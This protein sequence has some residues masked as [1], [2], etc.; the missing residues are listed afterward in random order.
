M[1]TWRGTEIAVVGMAGRFPGAG[2]VERFWQNL[3]AGVESIR[4]LAREEL[5]ALGA[6]PALADEPS[7][8]P[9]VAM[10]D[11]YADFDARFFGINPREAE[12]MDP[13]Q[14]VFLE[15]A[16]EALEDAGYDPL[17]APGEVGVFA[18]STLSTYLLF[19]LAR[20]QRIVAGADPLQLIVGNA[21]DS[22]TTRVSYKLNLRGP[23]HTV[24][25]AC[26]T[27]LVAVHLA[28]QSLL[29]EACDMALAGGVSIH[30]H[31]AAG[32]RF[33]EGSILSPD[34]HCRPF[35][36]A[37]QGTLFASGVGVVVLKRL[38]DA[39]ADGDTVRAVILG[40]AVNNDGAAKV[41]FTAPSVDG[42]ARVIAEALAVAGVA[43]E[44]I[45]YVEAH[46]T[47]TALGDPVE[48]QALTRAFGAATD[49]RACA[50]G[51]LK[52]NFG[53]LDIAAGVAALIKTVLA[54]E[55]GEIPPSLHLAAPNPRIDF[56][57]SRV[58]VANRLADWPRNGAPR[59]A[60]VSSF[61][62]GGT[63]A[64]VVLEEAPARAAPVV[65]AEAPWQL[66]LLSARSRPALEAA[67]RRL[68]GHL[69]RRP[70]Q[71][72]GD[73]AHTLRVG[74]RPFAERRMAVCRDREDAAAALTALDP[75]RVATAALDEAAGERP[76]A[77]LF[78]GQ[79]SQ[80]LQMARQLFEHEPLFRHELEEC[81]R[82]LAPRLG[83]PLER[84]LYP[85]PGEEEAAAALLAEMRV[86]QPA[87]FAVEHA[88]ARTWMALGITPQAMLGHSLGEYVAACLAGVFTLEEALALVAERGE[89]MQQAPA[90][91]ML[92]VPLPAAE[93]APLLPP[94]VVVAAEN[95]PAVTA[96]AGSAEAITTLEAMF[97][98][99][100]VECRRLHV[101]VAAH[102]P[103]ME[104]IRE[105]FVARVAQ[106]R[107]RPPQIPFV[108]NLTGRWITDAEA[109]DPAYWGRHLCQPVRF[110]AG[111][112]TLLAGSRAAL[113]EVGPGRTLSTL[114]G[115]HPDVAAERPLLASLG[116]PQEKGEPLQRFLAAAGRLWLAGARIDWVAL[117]AGRGRRRVP[118][119]TYP[120]ERQRYWVDPDG[121][122]FS[123]PGAGVP[124]AAAEPL[125]ERPA[126]PVGYVE[127]A[128]EV[129]RRVAA[130]WQELLGVA[131][132][133]REDNF[134][135]L[136]GHSLLA[137]QVASRL[138]E[139]FAV[140][141]PVRRVLEEP[142]V[143]GMAA[144]VAEAL[145]AAA[146]GRPEAGAVALEALAGPIPRE[147][148]SARAPLS[149]AQERMWFLGQLDPGSAAYN[150]FFAVRL[151]GPL[152]V[153]VLGAAF[154]ALAE[155]HEVLRT[156]IVAA[157][158]QPQQ[159]IAPAA[160]LAV[161]LVDLS[162]LAAAPRERALAGVVRQER[163]RLFTLA[164]P[165]LARVTL[166]LLTGRSGGREEAEEHVALL[167]MHHIVSDG[168]ST[169]VLVREVAALYEAFLAGRASPLPPL[170]LQYA[171]FAVW[172]RGYLQGE[173]LATLLAYWTEQL[174]DP[175]PPLR[176]ATDHPRGAAPG[177]RL[178]VVQRTLPPRLAA[179]L[180][181]L[182][183]RARAT[184]FMTL[185][186]GFHTLLYRA[187]GQSDQVIGSPIANRN[188]AAVEGLIGFF[189]NTLALRLRSAPGWSFRA[190]LEEVRQTALDAYAHQDLPLETLVEAL[191]TERGAGVASLF[192]VMFLL[193]NV[194]RPA[195]EVA[196]LTLEL[197]GDEGVADLGASLFDLCLV[198]EESGGSFVTSLTYDA[199]LFTRP[200]AERLLLR[201]E[202]LLAAAVAEP[203]Q[204]LTALPLLA[205]GEERQLLAWSAGDEAPP[206]TGAVH[207][208]F[209]RQAA[210]RPWAPAVVAGGRSV[211][212]GELD[213]RANRLAHHL[214][215][216]GV[217]P[218][219]R[220]AVCVER[221]PEMLV[222]VLA[223]L[224][225]GGAYVPL[226]AAYPAERKAVVLA[227]AGVRVAL[228]HERLAGQLASQVPRVLCLDAPPAALAGESEA[229]PRVAVAPGN[230]AYVLYT[231]G[232]TGRPKGVVVEH[233]ALAAFTVVAR[234]LYAIG[235]ADRVLQFASLAF[236]ASAEEIY[237][238]L[239]AGAALVLR[240]DA[241]LGA[242][243][244]LLE[245][246]RR[247]G[248]TV[249]D[250]PTAYWHEWAAGLEAAG[251]AVGAPLRL[252]ILG[253]ER[254]QPE[255]LASFAAR[256]DPGVRLLNTYGP[257]EATVVAS[258][259]EL[260]ADGVPPAVGEVPIGRP[261]PGVRCHV[262]DPLLHPAPIGLPGELCIG[263]AGLAR[264]Y[265]DR[266][267]WTAER[268][269]PDPVASE[270]GQRLY[271]T[272]DLARW[273]PDGTLEFVGRRD[274]QVKLRGF[275]IELG[276]IEAALRAQP[277]VQD[278]VAAVREDAPGDRRLVAYVVAGEDGAGDELGRDVRAALARQ[279]PDY[280]VPADV[281]P[282]AALPLTP[283]G[284]VDRRALPAPDRGR[285][286]LAVSYVPPETPT[287]E[288]L[289]RLFAAVLG[290]ERVGVR[291]GF[292]ALGGHSLLLVQLLHRVREAFA[293][294]LP[295]RTLYEEPTVAGL[296]LVV[297]ELIL[298][299]I[300]SLEPAR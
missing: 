36:A 14:R 70:E 91:A 232:S 157:E 160:R 248:V 57:A 38:A 242:A 71:S 209:A 33:L 75:Q 112:A 226:D 111:L 249:L 267:D 72:L 298:A 300:E 26:S 264:G 202:M 233:G 131:L 182:G 216:L 65:A 44:T 55:H 147:P 140:E 47:G 149:F 197:L 110:T 120:F 129:E 228:T 95:A 86:A 37:A 186:A 145:A 172:Q 230:A 123:A 243:A 81:S 1:P 8:V 22:L 134:F 142:S 245:A 25:C 165:P 276:E 83:V 98:G 115:Q 170:A 152:Q 189:L 63:N 187:T 143:A 212:Y 127:P 153:P 10:L 39:L 262:L 196:G 24:Q 12:T 217:G 18:G 61:G 168:W 141:L 118:L 146:A 45:G 2:D 88:L 251:L 144:A 106:A 56:T 52:S 78:P 163:E 261:L 102:S 148:W 161:S 171:D 103:L 293:V 76:V 16:W 164:E 130:I 287:E 139:A 113:L 133:G 210:E 237:P 132:V 280:M 13:Q 9:A 84:V 108:S 181:E 104:P 62:L 128:D 207:E 94:G 247:W 239:T 178:A 138:R 185:L 50:I 295:L 150:V 79:G 296:A 6:D 203:E 99:R 156:G 218:E 136:G 294:D 235:P 15:C 109:T 180:G 17:A 224:K 154:A 58:Y 48:V 151:R 272:G 5:A 73:V 122:T 190:L 42:Q 220:V 281:M 254:A 92:S 167:A 54:L 19:N 289:C 90:G 271:R 297:E 7:W 34:G 28:C 162:G 282:L 101:G 32:Y 257:T 125:Y 97:A 221:S 174:A 116:H 66:L 252:V 250:L 124:A 46:G 31:G 159:V 41:G 40:S 211:S 225:A 105:R 260:P 191:Q 299:E 213:R 238:A 283:Q 198:V 4:F 135:D 273:L 23:S 222:A 93:L 107:L 119:P 270:P 59:R 179:D 137:T 259:W 256:L 263:G 175:P 291:D 219:A 21:G 269:V 208:L 204:P 278:A 77:F 195:R 100:G 194:P 192:Q 87:L 241:M 173:T 199:H 89:L 114:A 121:A 43:A 69:A 49:R 234:D 80:H 68:A 290:R 285:P 214:R 292:F 231:S 201:F 177:Q 64:H 96:V 244:A 53:H 253:G 176:L 275:R 60:G 288:L 184:P 266:P 279:L 82:L 188:R 246:C 3:R 67:T 277:G 215:R 240:D 286:G 227:E 229:D 206:Y 193:Q 268:F 126:L 169:A 35:D 205:P 20:S 51:S 284:K 74:R 11:G 255:R 117:D 274:E 85:D 158:G 155:R 29:D 183:R 166:A 27:S 200:T 30:V 258:A 236:D 223:V 265:L